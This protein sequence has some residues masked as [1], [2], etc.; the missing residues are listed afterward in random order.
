MLMRLVFALALLCAAPAT[1]RETMRQYFAETST[2]VELLTG[3]LAGRMPRSVALL[4]HESQTLVTWSGAS[5]PPALASFLASAFPDLDPALLRPGRVM[6]LVASLSPA[7][8]GTAL[9]LMVL[10]RFPP[11]SVDMPAG[12][13]VMLDATSPEPCTGQ[14]VLKHPGVRTEVAALYRAHFDGQGFLFDDGAS[15]ETSFLV[16]YA[17]GCALG[18]YFQRDGEAT[19]V[20]ARYLEE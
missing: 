15:G 4:S 12:A 19:L 13:A 20:V 10:A 8:N 17:E 7:E 1:A 9:S 18:L 6:S 5:L 14:I 11:L 16:G 2:G 3:E